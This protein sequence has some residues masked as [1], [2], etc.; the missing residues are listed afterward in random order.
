MG[1]GVL[2][3]GLPPWGGSWIAFNALSVILEAFDVEVPNLCEVSSTAASCAMQ[4]FGCEVWCHGDLVISAGG[5]LENSWMHCAWHMWPLVCLVSPCLSG[6]DWTFSSLA[7]GGLQKNL[8]NLG[9]LEVCL[10]GSGSEQRSRGATQD[11]IEKSLRP[12]TCKRVEGLH[13]GTCNQTEAEVVCF[14]YAA[15]AEGP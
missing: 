8:M 12:G 11:Q 10:G 9:V 2:G 7:G 14:T 4:Q 6:G 3:V 5:M 15:F 13:L 1:L